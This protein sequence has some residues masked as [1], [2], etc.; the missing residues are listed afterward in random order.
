MS[1]APGVTAVYSN[2]LLQTSA[3]T[4]LDEPLTIT[5]SVGVLFKSAAGAKC[6]VY[7][8]KDLVQVLDL[9]QSSTDRVSELHVYDFDKTLVLTPEEREG[10]AEYYRV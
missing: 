5:G 4:Q 6:H 9:G 3:M 7:S 2:Q 8:N 1:L 10:Q